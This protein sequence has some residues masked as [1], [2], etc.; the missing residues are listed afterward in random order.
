MTTLSKS[1]A[2]KI[3]SDCFYA[4]P[5][6]IFHG[7]TSMRDKLYN[8]ELAAEKQHRAG[9]DAVKGFSAA[10][11]AKY[12]TVKH[13]IDLRHQSYS[14]ESILDIR[15][16]CLYAQAYASRYA[17]ELKPFFEYVKASQ[18]GEID[19]AELMK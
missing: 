8:M 2:N 13:L 16:E 12:F 11:A 4:I 6:N 7:F 5:D 15:N 18:F 9:Y 3:I 10:Q 17:E 14:V 19:Y 1:A